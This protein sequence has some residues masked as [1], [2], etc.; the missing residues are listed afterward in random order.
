MKKILICTAA[1]S[2]TWMLFDFLVHG[3]YLKEAYEQTANLWRPMEEIQQNWWM[4]ILTVVSAFIY[5]WIYCCNVSDKSAKT[6][7]TFSAK[8]GTLMA[9]SFGF[10]MYAVMP[11]PCSMAMTWFV[12]T[13][14]AFLLAGLI[15][16]KLI[17][18]C[19]CPKS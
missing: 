4:H 2:I 19:C 10:G 7:L 15:T 11:I 18:E 3:I 9:I 5:T 8:V 13:L 12:S 6:A 17:T 16:G 14:V 1:I